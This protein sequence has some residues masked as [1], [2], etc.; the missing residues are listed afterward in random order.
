MDGPL[1]MLDIDQVAKT[2]NNLISGLKDLVSLEAL[3]DS[4]KKEVLSDFKKKRA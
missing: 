3:S 1:E 4:E 2:A